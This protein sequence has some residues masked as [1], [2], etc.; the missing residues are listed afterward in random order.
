[1]RN[2]CVVPALHKT[3][4]HR[5]A[6]VRAY[7]QSSKRNAWK[8]N[9]KS[10]FC[11]GAKA[12]GAHSG[13]YAL[14]NGDPFIVVALSSDCRSLLSKAVRGNSFNTVYITLMRS[15]LFNFSE[16]SSIVAVGSFFFKDG[17]FVISFRFTGI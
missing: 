14:S 13:V 5:R 1:M 3:R 4:S 7:L 17:P 6:C 10:E 15:R 12:Y 2:I 11:R 8:W 9:T 16:F